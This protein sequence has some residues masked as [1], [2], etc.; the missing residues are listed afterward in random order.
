MMAFA[1]RIM[2][3]ALATRVIIVC[4]VLVALLASQW[5]LLNPLAML[6]GG[7][8]AAKPQISAIA[9]LLSA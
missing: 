1:V 8:F 6:M 3:L 2:I 4:L 5:I 7:I 9:F